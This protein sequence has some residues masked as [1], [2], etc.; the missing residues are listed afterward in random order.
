MLL[1]M[2]ASSNAKHFIYKLFLNSQSK[3]KRNIF[4]KNDNMVS[5]QH[6]IN[7][8]TSSQTHRDTSVTF[9]T[10][11]CHGVSHCSVKSNLLLWTIGIFPD[12]TFFFGS[13]RNIL[14]CKL[15]SF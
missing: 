11:K 2:V 12:Q 6:Y 8:F 7:V 15:F 9:F 13:G 1:V 4:W 14:K 10:G 5:K 3:E